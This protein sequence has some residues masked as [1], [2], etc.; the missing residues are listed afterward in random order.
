MA[1]ETV[2]LKSFNITTNGSCPAVS[3]SEDSLL[4]GS[5]PR[6]DVEEV[7]TVEDVQRLED[8]R[9]YDVPPNEQTE[10]DV[11]DTVTNINTKGIVQDEKNKDNQEGAH[12]VNATNAA[13]SVSDSD[14]D[15]LDGPREDITIV[16]CDLYESTEADDSKSDAD[17]T[18]EIPDSPATVRARASKN[19]QNRALRPTSIKMPLNLCLPQSSDSE[20]GL[21]SDFEEIATRHRPSSMENSKDTEELNKGLEA[22]PVPLL[23]PESD[24]DSEYYMSPE[25]HT[26]RPPGP[27]WKPFHEYDPVYI[28]HSDP[29]GMDRRVDNQNYVRGR[30][31][32]DSR[33]THPYEEIQFS[34]IY[35]TVD[36]E[37]S[38]PVT[39]GQ[40]ETSF[41]K[42]PLPPPIV[43]KRTRPISGVADMGRLSIH[44]AIEPEKN[45]EPRYSG[46]IK[47]DVSD[48]DDDTPHEYTALEYTKLRTQ[49]SGPMIS[50]DIKHID[51]TDSETY[52]KQAAPPLLKRRKG[53]DAKEVLPNGDKPPGSYCP[54][55]KQD[56]GQVYNGKE[57]DESDKYNSSSD[58]DDSY[59][60]VDFHPPDSPQAKEG[61]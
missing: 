18:Y 13:R 22:P 53:S 42:P 21:D 58:S 11:C 33:M 25:C 4:Q 3:G 7:F 19:L 30:Q 8:D 59:E 24:T 5:S 60:P 27:G 40:P 57:N 46:L 29:V 49:E 54:L 48:P 41:W 15:G 1:D 28:P 20:S 61:S 37:D 36:G 17:S 6:D 38:L 34:G 44:R 2:P 9:I 14:N 39:N 56:Y 16:E 45:Q 31:R 35:A 51:D 43:P 26:H 23:P 47:D 32:S 50:D 55:I 10:D 52:A 12:A